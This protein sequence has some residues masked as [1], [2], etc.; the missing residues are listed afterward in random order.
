MLICSCEGHVRA[1]Q[2]SSV[3]KNW[4]GGSSRQARLARDLK[5]RMQIRNP[6]SGRWQS[7]EEVEPLEESTPPQMYVAL[8]DGSSHL[9]GMD[10]TVLTREPRGGAGRY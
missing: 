10:E 9:I 8:D 4:A 3:S 5:P 6:R 1:K 2:A 7:I